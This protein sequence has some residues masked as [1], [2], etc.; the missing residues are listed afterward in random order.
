MNDMEKEQLP[1]VCRQCREPDCWECDY[2]GMRW[3]Q[4]E[5]ER[6]M[7]ARK[8]KESAI[9]RYQRQIAEIDRRLAALPAK[10]GRAVGQ[11][12]AHPVEYNGKKQE[13]AEEGGGIPP[14][15]IPRERS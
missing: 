9:A 2:A 3:E 6:L 4:S 15:V 12:A 7:H 8:L 14:L 13:G 11:C 10:P 5:R 1:P